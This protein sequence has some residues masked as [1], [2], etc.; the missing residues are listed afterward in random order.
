MNKRKTK[1]FFRFVLG[2]LATQLSCY[3]VQQSYQPTPTF[4]VDVQT[5]P[6]ALHN[7]E[8]IFILKAVPGSVCSVVF[9]YWNKKD[10]WVGTPLLTSNADNDGVCQFTWKV[11]D[12]AK[13]GEAEIRGFVEAGDEEVSFIPQV[14]CI[15]K[16]P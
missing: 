10:D 7:Q 8:N 4:H 9:L 13:D 15:E 11:P 16:C 6:I 5:P 3:G 12:D 14:F 1:P 2:L